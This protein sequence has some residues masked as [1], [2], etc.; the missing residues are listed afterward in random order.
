MPEPFNAV[1]MKRLLFL[2]LVACCGSAAFAQADSSGYFTS[3]DGTR[4][5]FEA[6]GK[7]APVVLVH[8]F[9][10]DGESWKRTALYEELIRT[11]HRVIS[12]D[13]RGNG[14]SGKPH[15]EEAYAHDAEA[16][17]IQLLLTAL[18]IGNYR[19]VG[20]SRGSIVVARLL[21]LD[22]RISCAVLGG[23]GDGFTDPQ[24][25]R[26][27]LFYRA[28]AGEP[29]AELA[30]MVKYVQD[31]KLDQQALALLQKMQ[32]SASAAELATVVQ[33]VLVICGDKDPDNGSPQKL[34]ALFPK[35]EL[36]L[37]PGDHNNALRTT[38]FS[39]A[40]R[41]FLAKTTN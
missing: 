5:F 16:R 36:A 21:L 17:D 10:V 37:I 13:L 12:F 7:G 9:I 23:M 26:R 40:V 33:P 30:G 38:A 18:G 1:I 31:S 34:A 41:A 24:W 39:E 35:A 11:G 19:V 6:K 20:Y 15:N 29:V 28:L 22:K 25:P 3:F 2:F 14:R 27:I 4:I 8:G 32:P